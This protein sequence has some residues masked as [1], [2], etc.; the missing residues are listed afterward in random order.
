MN[1]TIKND[2]FAELWQKETLIDVREV[3]EYTE[4]H[5]PTAQN[6]PLSQLENRFN[7][8]DK[9]LHYY[10]ICQSGRRSALACDL[11]ANQGYQVTNI[12]GGMAEWKGKIADGQLR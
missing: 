12:L 9:N 6:I 2:D 3:A 7:E 8:L 1:N 10:I 11:L 5:I 4:R